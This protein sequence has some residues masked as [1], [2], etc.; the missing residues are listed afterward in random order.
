LSSVKNQIRVGDE[1]TSLIIDFG[2]FKSETPHVVSYAEGGIRVSRVSTFATFLS[3]SSCSTIAST[4]YVLKFY[5]GPQILRQP[6]RLGKCPPIRNVFQQTIRL[7]T[8]QTEI[9]RAEFRIKRVIRV[10]KHD[11]LIVFEG[12]PDGLDAKLSKFRTSPEGGIGGA[13]IDR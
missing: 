6:H 2:F 11:T 13:E 5:T 1:V 4:F 12:I 10:G 8:V 7:Y 9:R 3:V